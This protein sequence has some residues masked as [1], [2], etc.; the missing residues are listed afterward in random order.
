ML[1]GRLLDVKAGE[2]RQKGRV[3]VQDA[4]GKGFDECR[5][6]DAHETGEADELYVVLQKFLY[7][8]R[9]VLIP[10]SLIPLGTHM[11]AGDAMLA[12]ALQC[13]GIGLIADHDGKL[14]RKLS[15][16]DVVDDRLE[17]GTAAGDEDAEFNLLHGNPNGG[18]ESSK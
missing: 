13:V 9:I 6:D 1:K 4:V 7:E 16:L 11:N 12:R 5:C 14:G 10:F 17:V 8:K 15:C 2:S 18:M 3:D